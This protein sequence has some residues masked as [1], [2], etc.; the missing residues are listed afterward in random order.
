M[1]YKRKYETV[2]ERRK[3]LSEAGK[4]GYRIAVDE[5]LRKGG[6]KPKPRAADPKG[7]TTICARSVDARWM[8]EIAAKLDIPRVQLLRVLI[9]FFRRSVDMNA[10][11]E[12]EQIM[13]SEAAILFGQNALFAEDVEEEEE[14]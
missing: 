12:V 10:S 6:R 11:E 8:D 13:K 14:W 5:G 4:L 7:T 9:Q 1:A 3:A 2:E